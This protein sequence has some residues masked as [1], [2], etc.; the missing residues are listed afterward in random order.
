VAGV[1]VSAVG[2]LEEAVSAALDV[3][4]ALVVTGEDVG[5]GIAVEVVRRSRKCYP[6]ERRGQAGQVEKHVGQ[7]R[8]EALNRHLFSYASHPCSSPGRPS[9]QT[10]CSTKI[11]C[12]DD[13]V[14]STVV[15][16]SWRYPAV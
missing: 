7:L 16:A 12:Y 15:V 10:S 4:V 5:V 3:F 13:F 8:G 6:S 11:K 14:H 9:S 2:V 1:V